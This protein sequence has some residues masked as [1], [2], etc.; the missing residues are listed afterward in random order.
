MPD[1]LPQISRKTEKNEKKT[2]R[3]A[4]VS[5][6]VPLRSLCKCDTLKKKNTK[7]LDISLLFNATKR[8]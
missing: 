4:E 8:E 3:L 5:E 7:S 1:I 6:T 2:V